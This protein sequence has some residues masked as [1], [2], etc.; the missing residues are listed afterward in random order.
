MRTFR[1]IGD[2]VPKGSRVSGVSKSGVRFNREANSR[3]G[4]ATRDAV[5]Q[6][7]A[8]H[9]GAPLRPPYA[10]HITLSF[11]APQKRSWPRSGDADK[12]ARHLLDCMSCGSSTNAGIIEDDRHVIELSC[13]KTYAEDGPPGAVIVVEELDDY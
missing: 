5:L 4:P 8:Q 6:L 11:K 10:V 2:P 9:T 7:K 12:Y 3:V 1:I 13:R